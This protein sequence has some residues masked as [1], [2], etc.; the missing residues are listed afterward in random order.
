MNRTVLLL[1]LI[2]SG[3]IFVS[4]KKND[5]PNRDDQYTTIEIM[6][7][8][9]NGEKLEGVYVKM[10]DEETYT[11][12]KENHLT[13]AIAESLTDKNGIAIFTLENSKWYNGK[14]SIELM[15]TVVEHTDNRNY[16]FSSKG[17]TVSKNS[18]VKFTIIFLDEE[19]SPSSSL[20]IENNI[21]KSVT[22]KNLTS[23]VLPSNVKEIAN[24]V[25]KE[26][27][28][29]EIILNEGLETIGD[30]CFL[31]SK[32]KEINF[33]SSLKHIGKA[34]FQDCN[35]LEKVDLSQTEIQI[36]CE[37]A[38]ID[39]GLKEI[40]LPSN[41]KEI[42]SQAF[43]GTGNLQNISIS[44]STTVIGNK[45]FCKSGLTSIT[46]HNGLK[47]IGYMAFAN[48]T[49]LKKISK[50][51]ESTNTEGRILIGAFQ[52]CTSLTEAT[53]PDNITIMEGYTFIGCEQLGKII[54]SKNLKSIG[55]LGLRTN[56]DVNTIVFNSLEIPELSNIPESSIPNV[57]P[58][59][60]N[61][62]EILV[63]SQSV[64]EYKNRLA[65]YANKIKGI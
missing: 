30:A 3:L 28:I 4:C 25:F 40:I 23:I 9:K 14:T 20:V 6:V 11:L 1:L 35:M 51:S 44:Q 15:F 47:T 31:N 22:D 55:D 48:C 29:T 60:D 12:F 27:N 17:G 38:F 65:S 7:E 18:K 21:L 63:P 57:L 59:V 62:N 33:P 10:F 53:L 39:S 43:Y 34:A 42:A 19:I 56:Y 8:N 61:I 50:T 2:C 49:G 46:L 26:S 58:F 41:L 52:D 36:I 45:A 24:N 16:K 64:D 32:I 37:S 13:K 5:I 54:L